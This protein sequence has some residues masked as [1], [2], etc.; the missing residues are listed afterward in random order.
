[1]GKSKENTNILK[2]QKVKEKFNK[3]EIKIGTDALNFLNEKIDKN[4]QETIEK[5]KYNLNLEGKKV[6][7][8]KDV[9]EAFNK[10][11]KDNFQDF[12]I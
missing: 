2:K 3:K 7:R 1:M 8:L 5:I 6:A 12:E 9:Q 10:E 11:T 4:L